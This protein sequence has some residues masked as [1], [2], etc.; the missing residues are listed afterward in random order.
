MAQLE[1]ILKNLFPYQIFIVMALMIGIN[2]Y[3][4]RKK[5]LPFFVW[6]M[7][8]LVFLESFL[9]S[10]W[11][12]KFKT[13][14]IILNITGF[15]TLIY[16]FYVYYNYFKL[17]KV[18]NYIPVLVVIYLIIAIFESDFDIKTL[19]FNTISYLFGL[20]I[21]IGLILKYFYD[22]LYVD[23][24]RSI[25]GE[26]LFYFSLGILI[27]YVSCFPTLVNYTK[28]FQKEITSN[29]FSILINL[30]NIFL[31][32]GYLGAALCMK[33]PSQ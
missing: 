16:Y 19:Q 33:K 3:L 25:T 29:L 1:L 12:I 5:G 2:N 8:M 31:S 7:L 18:K 17:K 21:V 9:K 13:N 10:F 24:Y 30:G 14:V 4:H 22:I 23:E 27:F 15:Y 6:F 26:A 11:A 32:L 28:I 20:T